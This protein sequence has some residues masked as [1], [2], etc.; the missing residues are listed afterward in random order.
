MSRTPF[1]KLIWMLIAAA[2]IDGVEAAKRASIS[3]SRFYELSRGKARPTPDETRALLGISVTP[4]VMDRILLKQVERDPSG[5]AW[6]LWRA[7]QGLDAR[8]A[9]VNAKLSIDR[10]T[11]TADTRSKRM[12][13]ALAA[14]FGNKQ[15]KGGS[16]HYLEHYELA[17]AYLEFEPRG[18]PDADRRRYA[19]LDLWPSAL[20]EAGACLQL[21]DK[22]DVATAVLTR[23]DVAV[24]LDV[25]LRS[26][27]VIPSPRTK[28]R[29]EWWWATHGLETIYLFRPPRRICIYDKARQAGLPSPLTRIEAQ[30]KKPEINP[31][32]LLELPNPFGRFEFVQLG[33][34]GSLAE[35]LIAREARLFGL[36]AVL[37]GLPTT[38]QSKLRAT[39]TRAAWLPHPRAVF[40]AKWKPAALQLMK[41]FGW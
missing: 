6:T 1:T 3:E 16:S 28:A 2:G 24:D 31:Y 4:E 11:L 32:Q 37:A 30:L 18:A 13:R 29:V 19:R 23:V 12:L 26:I 21:L 25:S 40:D 34:A 39:L 17:N 14:Q 20:D 41:R 27:H 15:S 22:L 38:E 9:Q 35:Q 8:P 7:A 33:F 10:L 36:P 5:L